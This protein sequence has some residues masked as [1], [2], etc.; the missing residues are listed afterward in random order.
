MNL[1]SFQ[2]SI[3]NFIHLAISIIAALLTLARAISTFR[4]LFYFTTRLLARRS[5]ILITSPF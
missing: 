1:T 2:A 4:I 3:A 5:L